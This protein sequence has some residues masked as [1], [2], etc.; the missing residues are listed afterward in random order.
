MQNPDEPGRPVNSPKWN[1]QVTAE[2]LDVL[3]AYG[4]AEW[5]AATDRYLTALPGLKAH[6]AAEREMDRKSTRLNTTHI[7]IYRMP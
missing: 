6:Y 4:T 7:T 1:Y 2:A 3:R 5:Q